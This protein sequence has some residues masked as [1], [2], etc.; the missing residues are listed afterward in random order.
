M[1]LF[2]RMVGRCL[3]DCSS[4][5]QIHSTKPPGEPRELATRYLR[6]D[7][8]WVVL[9]CLVSSFPFV[10]VFFCRVVLSHD[11]DEMI[12]H[13]GGHSSYMDMHVSLFVCASARSF[14]SSFACL[15]D[16][17]FSASFKHQELARIASLYRT[18]GA[19]FISVQKRTTELAGRRR[20]HRRTWT[21]ALAQAHSLTLL[22]LT[23]LTF[24]Q[25]IRI[26]VST[27]IV[28]VIGCSW[29][30]WDQQATKSAR[31]LSFFISVTELHVVPGHVVDFI[32]VLAIALNR[33]EE[34]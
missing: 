6:C 7:G 2:I 23:Y 27:L 14:F 30:I 24:I 22:N 3:S 4:T 18:V 31:V 19:P 1:F 26:P 9:S 32:V 8:C 33:T 13:G 16:T 28:V 5:F 25:L 34:R 21:Q 29:A 17:C 12:T 20:S 15:S 11:V 10:L